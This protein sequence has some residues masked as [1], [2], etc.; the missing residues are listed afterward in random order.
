M[1]EPRVE[2]LSRKFLVGM[3]SSMCLSVDGTQSLWGRFMPRRKEIENTVS[4]KFYSMQCYPQMR[5]F[6]D[7]GATTE[8][9]K[10]AA[11]E[12]AGLYLIPKGMDSYVFEGG[13]YAVFL[14]RGPATAAPAVFAYIFSQWL[15]QSAYELD[16]REHFEVLG[17][18]YRPDDPAAEEEIWIP[19]K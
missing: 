19:I 13:E 7:L 3:H 10:W 18:G 8:F 4:E 5:T 2:V 16:D 12:V 1:D 15:P 11:V 14:H 9:E 6:A 17:P